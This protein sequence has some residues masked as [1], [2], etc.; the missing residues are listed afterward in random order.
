M[1]DHATIADLER[2]LAAAEAALREKADV[3]AAL[4]QSEE[5]RRIAVEG[6]RMGTWRWDLRDALI[7][8]DAAFLGLWGFPPSDDPR[9]L[10]DFTVRMS[11]Q[12]RGEM[13]EMVT[14][15]IAAGQEFDGQL[16]VVAGLTIGHWVRWRGRADQERPWIVNGV[17]FDVTDQ[18]LKGERLT[19][20][21]ARHRLL[22]ES[23]TQAVWETDAHGV[24]TAD[25]PSWR[26]YT[27][28]TLEAW[29]GHGWLDAIHPYDRA[30]AERQWREAVAAQGL[31]NAEFRLRAPDGGWRWTNVRAAPVRDARGHVEKWVGMNID[32][33]ARKR[34]ETALRDSEAR[35][36][37]AFASVPA[38]IAVID[39]DGKV[40]IA[41]DEYRRFLPNGTMP[42]RGPDRGDRWRAWDD[43]RLIA[44]HDYP[45]SRALRGDR[46]VPGLEMLFVDDG[47]RSFWTNVA[48]APTFDAAGQ[49]TGFVSVISD[50]TE[51]KEAREAARRAE[52]AYRDALER[53]VHVRTVELTASRDLLQATMDSSMDMIQVFAAIRDASG[54][55]VDF[56]W[57]L[58]NHTSESRYGDVR[59]QS[60][61]ERNP[62]VVQE[63][64]FDAFKRVTETGVPSSAERHYV[65]EQFDGWFF[66]S[67][68][69]LGDGVATTTKE[70]TA[71]K[72][73]QAEVLRLQEEMAQA[74][75]HES[76]ERL[77]QFGEA[78]SDVLWMRDAETLQWIYFTPAFETIY[79]LDRETALRGDN[80]SGWL[81]LI[82]PEDRQAV[83]DNIRQVRAGGPAAFEYRIRR[84]GDGAVRWIRDTDFPMCD[85]AGRVRWL[86]GVGRDITEEKAAAQRQAILVN[87]LQHR[88]R[89][90]L[91]IVAALADRTVR[92]GGSVEAFE[93]RLQALG[94]A[95]GLLS[96]GGSD[97]VAVGRLVRTEL[98]AHVD[99]AADRVRVAGPELLLRARQVQN[100]ALA[101][102]ELTTNAVK[103]GAL[104]AD[105]GRLSVTWAIVIDDRGGRRL[106]LNWVEEGVAIDPD[107]VIRRGYG[108]ELIQEALAY[109]LRAEVDYTL[110][111]DGVRCR[112]DMPVA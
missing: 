52:E 107:T 10:S 71:W 8:G 43:G 73:A 87:E 54:E 66:Q 62:G 112:I 79:G 35:L 44:P 24:V 68:V 22:I 102:H 9:P 72:A 11:P 27:G 5:L 30:Y 58:N 89:N 15:A 98:A 108:T 25:S 67:A 16:A 28:Q 70:I 14:R 4:R 3:E 36:S 78:S 21:E 47:G 20:S 48:T 85:A 39:I 18:Q 83:L 103:Y 34:T 33:D 38:G 93:E 88:A 69:K 63:G 50:I 81:D 60:L 65:H 59:G 56:R 1:D 110:G 46:V 31:V 96:Q 6:G 109:A 94:R 91:G 32:I 49:V 13:G 7:W 55:I 64:I 17:S 84:R 42:S 12:G 76:E 80:M 97:T 86:G 57:L 74:K 2:R 105:T 104:K 51:R 75:V 40:V 82:V 29:L 23:W 90:L 61:L 45:G 92:Q 37:A 26:A 41:N 95:Q 100:F 106:T 99:G 77:R 19:E 53:Q 101:L 111:A